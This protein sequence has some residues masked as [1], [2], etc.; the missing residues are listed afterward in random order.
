MAIEFGVQSFCFRN[1]KDNVEVAK[2]VKEIGLDAIELCRLHV[3]FDNPE[4][5]KYNGISLYLKSDRNSRMNKW[6]EIL[7]SY[8]LNIE[9][10]LLKQLS[11]FVTIVEVI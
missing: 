1:T 6:H 7:S 5:Y 2:L 8:A 9:K 11:F 3:D 4:V 10:R